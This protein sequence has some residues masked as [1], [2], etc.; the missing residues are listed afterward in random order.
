[1]SAT[2]QHAVIE[3]LTDMWDAAV[4]FRVT[5]GP[6]M[7]VHDEPIFLSVGYDPIND[8]GL[9]ANTRQDYT[10]I[11]GRRKAEE[12]TIRSTVA[13]WS[14]DENTRERRRQVADALSQLEAALRNDISLGGL[15][16]WANFGPRVD[17]NQMIT[18]RG[19]QVYARF[20]VTYEARI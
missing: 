12:G 13:A 14:G 9:A 11:G 4:E 15:V 8:D 17:L 19:N 1:M 6:D 16:L 3:Y 5:D 2:V 10:Q 20:D 18:D 7:S